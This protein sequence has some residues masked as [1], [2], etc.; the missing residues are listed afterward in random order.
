MALN[1]H[2]TFKMPT[3]GCASIQFSATILATTNVQLVTSTVQMLAACAWTCS[4][5]SQAYRLSSN[6]RISTV[7]QVMR[8]FCIV[9]MWS[10]CTP[11]WCGPKKA[12]PSCLHTFTIVTAFWPFIVAPLKILADTFAHRHRPH[13]TNQASP[14]PSKSW[15]TV[16]MVA[17]TI[18]RPSRLS[19]RSKSCT[20]CY[21]AATL[22]CRAKPPA[23]HIRP[24]FGK[25]F[26]SRLWA[27]IFNKPATFCALSTLT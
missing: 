19:N 20:P 8:S 6:R 9:A 11:H 4:N 26:T 14:T 15:S 17:T 27:R 21:R 25:R 23:I 18:D 5:Q 2:H 22:V 7:A 16:M 12:S 10:T 24:S 3:V 13:Q 1:C